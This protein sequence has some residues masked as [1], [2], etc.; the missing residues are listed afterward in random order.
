MT[1]QPNPRW[2]EAEILEI[3]SEFK[4]GQTYL[5]IGEKRGVSRHAIAGIIHRARHGKEGTRAYEL[6]SSA[7]T[8]WTSHNIVRPRP[9]V[10]RASPRPTPQRALAR[11]QLRKE[12]KPMAKI[13][14]P[15]PPGPAWR[16]PGK[17]VAPTKSKLV[18]PV[19]ETAV[20]TLDVR[21]G[22]CRAPVGDKVGADMLMC[23]A[24]TA[25]GSAWCD[26]CSPS[27]YKEE[28][29]AARKA[30]KKLM[31]GLGAFS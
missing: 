13:A 10:V 9:P 11:P 26:D 8:R 19:T 2:K 23:G 30:R 15:P 3:I 5:S 22:Q 14:K 6:I 16:Q 27:L 12:G 31:S 25:D 18:R 4:D 7:R 20:T 17:A 21:Y 24:P 29:P 1:Q 28:S